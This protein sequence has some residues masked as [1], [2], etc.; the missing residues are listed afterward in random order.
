MQILSAQNQNKVASSDPAAA[1][2]AGLANQKVD[3]GPARGGQIFVQVGAF[4]QYE[5]AHKLAARLSL[6]GPVGVS[7][8][9]VN[10]QEFFRVRL[11]PYTQ[12]PGAAQAL[13]QAINKIGRAS[14]RERVGQYV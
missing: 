11:G 12:V 4:S 14:C 8:T 7:S 13:Q 3:L 2:V 5:N 9:F 1:P 10:K 6:I